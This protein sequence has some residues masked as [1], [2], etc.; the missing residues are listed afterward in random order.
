MKFVVYMYTL[1]PLHIIPVCKKIG[2][3]VCL[4]IGIHVRAKVAPAYRAM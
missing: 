1:G 3:I 2:V 4:Q